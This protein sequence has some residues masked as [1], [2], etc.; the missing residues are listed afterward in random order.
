MTCIRHAAP[1]REQAPWRWRGVLKVDPIVLDPE[2]HVRRLGLDVELIQEPAK[3]GIRAIVENN[4]AGIHRKRLTGKGNVN[5]VRVP[6]HIVVRFEKV[7]L[8][9]IP[10]LICSDQSRNPSSYNCYF[11]EERSKCLVNIYIYA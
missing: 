9:Q 4:E 8:G 2:T 11:H 3:V 6:A 5:R 1:L 10:E 7:D